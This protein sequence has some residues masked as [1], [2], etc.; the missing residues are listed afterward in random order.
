MQRLTNEIQAE[1]CLATEPNQVHDPVHASFSQ[2]SH[3][4]LFDMIENEPDIE[5]ELPNIVVHED[6]LNDPDLVVTFHDAGYVILFKC[7]RRNY[8]YWL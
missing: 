6:D 7:Y 1:A 3:F 5:G 4:P 8:S 2:G